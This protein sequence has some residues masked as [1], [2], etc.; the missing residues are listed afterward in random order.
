MPYVEELAEKE[1]EQSGAFL[2][3]KV[4]MY[5]HSNPAEHFVQQ[6]SL[7][8]MQPY[9]KLIMLFHIAMKVLLQ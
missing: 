3:K 7:K 6:R 1:G 8:L 9:V 2:Q 4:N 5:S